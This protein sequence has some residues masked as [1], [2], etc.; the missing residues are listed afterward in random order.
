LKKR[1]ERGDL[2]IDD[3]IKEFELKAK[4]TFQ[5]ENE[6]TKEIKYRPTQTMH[7]RTDS[8][9]LKTVK[10]TEMNHQG[11]FLMKS[12]TNEIVVEFNDK[13][14]VSSGNQ[15]KNSREQYKRELHKKRSTYDHWEPE[16]GKASKSEGKA[17]MKSSSLL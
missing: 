11:N 16:V 13:T 14:G 6:K 10:H 9:N 3:A 17:P 1:S 15:S 7:E 2:K 12:H 5:S 4:A 8:L